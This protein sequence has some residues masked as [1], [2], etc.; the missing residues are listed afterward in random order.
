MKDPVL[1]NLDINSKLG[2]NSELI[3]T[4]GSRKMEFSIIGEYPVGSVK[5]F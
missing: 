2:S 5:T 1:K 4:T 3:I